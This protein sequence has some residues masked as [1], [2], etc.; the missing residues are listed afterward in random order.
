MR[1]I[2]AIENRYLTHEDLPDRTSIPEETD[3]VP[4]TA[5]PKEEDPTE[6]KIV[7]SFDEEEENVVKVSDIISEDVGT[8]DTDEL[9]AK[10][11]AIGNHP[12]ES[13]E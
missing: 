12:F 8:I 13:A 11:A 6:Q 1:N 7:P 10:T 5:E 2:Y 9:I 3:E 4:Q